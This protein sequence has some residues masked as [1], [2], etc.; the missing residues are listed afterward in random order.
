MILPHLLLLSRL[1]FIKLVV[2]IGSGMILMG[3]LLQSVNHCSFYDIN[4]IHDLTYL[5]VVRP[6]RVIVWSWDVDALLLQDCL[7]LRQEF[8]D[9]GELVCRQRNALLTGK[10]FAILLVELA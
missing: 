9:D 3:L 7:K 10:R 8:D 2:V 5:D 1:R 4:V 6:R